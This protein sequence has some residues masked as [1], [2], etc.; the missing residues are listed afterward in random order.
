MPSRIQNKLVRS[1]IAITS[2]AAPLHRL[3]LRT[4]KKRRVKGKRLGH[5]WAAIPVPGGFEARYVCTRCRLIRIG[6]RYSYG[7]DWG[8]HEPSCLLLVPDPRRC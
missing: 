5:A 1:H 7:V 8:R 3:K 4:L 6:R 2:V